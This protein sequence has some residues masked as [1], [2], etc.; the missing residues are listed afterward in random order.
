MAFSYSHRNKKNP[1][2]PRPLTREVLIGMN[3]IYWY[4]DVQKLPTYRREYASHI[5]IWTG[6]EEDIY[7][8][9][10]EH[11]RKVNW[12]RFLQMEKGMNE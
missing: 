5:G 6:E 1:S 10:M 8:T 9:Y 12:L 11:K 2:T 3:Y 4:E 7:K